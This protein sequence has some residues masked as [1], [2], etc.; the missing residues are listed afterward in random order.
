MRTLVIG[1]IHG[2]YQSLKAVLL[3]AN[4]DI[5]NDR[6]I[7]L[8]DYIDGFEQS[9]EVVEHL[10]DINEN[11]SFENIFIMGN[12]DSWMIEAL[13]EGLE[14]FRNHEFIES[15]YSS[16]LRN[17]GWSTYLSYLKLS[18]DEILKHKSKFYDLLKYFHIIGKKLYVHAGFD[19][20]VGFRITKNQNQQEFLWNR[21]LFES[22]YAKWSQR[23]GRID[24]R[25]DLANVEFDTIYIG[26]TPTVKFG[27]TEPVKMGNVLNLDQ[28]CKINGRLTAWIEEQE[29]FVQN[30]K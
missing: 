13:N 19:P 29:T 27:I 28:G 2:N 16:W 25:F 9:V 4:F 23:K 17:D 12:H 11:S 7:F 26:H 14:Q 15:K 21:S 30:T 3:K 18:D 20:D 5:D 22:A 24:K 6:L 10:I 1:D 8:G